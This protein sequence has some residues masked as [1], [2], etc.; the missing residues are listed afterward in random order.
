MTMGYDADEAYADDDDL[1]KQIRMLAN[2]IR[3]LANQGTHMMPKVNFAQPTFP[4]LRK[5]IPVAMSD[6]MSNV[7]IREEQSNLTANSIKCLFR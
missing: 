1:V 7:I 6:P 3:I 4:V 5:S 2:E